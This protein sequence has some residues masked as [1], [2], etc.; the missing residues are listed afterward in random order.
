MRR[1]QG[2]GGGKKK[3]RGGKKMGLQLLS[4]QS[5][6]RRR[7]KGETAKKKTERNGITGERGRERKLYLNP[8]ARSLY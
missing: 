2:K 7:G 4:N 8:P 3:G 6:K 5:R 1:F